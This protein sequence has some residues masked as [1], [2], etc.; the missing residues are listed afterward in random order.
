VYLSKPIETL[1]VNTEG[2]HHLLQLAIR[3]N[4]RFLFASTS[5]VYGDPPVHPQ[6]ET[7]WGNVSSIG[8]RSV[9]DEAKRYGEALVCAF[10]RQFDLPIRFDPNLRHYGLNMI[11]TTD[12]WCPI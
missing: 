5:E 8:T 4:A 9:Y 3:K 11:P 1:R 10:H 6:P 7:Y 2:T 12:A